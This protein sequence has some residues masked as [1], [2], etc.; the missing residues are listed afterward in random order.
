V[1]AKYH[2]ID[3]R[4]YRL[5]GNDLIVQV[6]DKGEVVRLVLDEQVIAGFRREH[7]LALAA[8][9]LEVAS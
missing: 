1:T 4:H 2:Q 3:V 5:E 9:L 7:A 8:L 6:H